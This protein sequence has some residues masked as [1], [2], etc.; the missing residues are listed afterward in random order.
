[1]SQEQQFDSLLA[2]VNYFLGLDNTINAVKNDREGGNKGGYKGKN[3]DENKKHEGYK[4][5]NN[6]N[7]N[8]GGTTH[9]T[10]DPAPKNIDP[11]VYPAPETA[12]FA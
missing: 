4:S 2:C 10:G 6:K 3:Y 7:S 8:V 9:Y 1:M 5:D 12:S 11:P